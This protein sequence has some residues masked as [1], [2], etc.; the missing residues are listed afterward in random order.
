[1]LDGGA[2]FYTVYQSK[3]RKYFAVGCIEK[4]F[5]KKFIKVTYS[6]LTPISTI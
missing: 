3:D 6:S 5:F 1:M 2:P 4:K